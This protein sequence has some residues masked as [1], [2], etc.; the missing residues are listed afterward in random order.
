MDDGFGRLIGRRTL[1]GVRWCL[2]EGVMGLD[3]GGAWVRGWRRLEKKRVKI[4]KDGRELRIMHIKG[5]RLHSTTLKRR[6]QLPSP[7]PGHGGHQR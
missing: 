1:E 2:G 4:L 3:D 5:H 6:G 7:I